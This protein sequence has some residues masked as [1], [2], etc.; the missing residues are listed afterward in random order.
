MRVSIVLANL[1]LATSALAAASPK[2][3]ARADYGDCRDTADSCPGGSCVIGDSSNPNSGYICSFPAATSSADS[4]SSSS[5][6]SSDSSSGSSGSYGDCRDTADSCPGGSCVAGDSSNPNSGYIC[7]FSSAAQTSAAASAAAAT[8]AKATTS[9]AAAGTAPTTIKAASTAASTT[10]RAASTT[11]L[12]ANSSTSASSSGSI[13]S[14]NANSGA[15]LTST[16]SYA[17]VAGSAYALL[18]LAVSL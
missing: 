7:S 12:A 15:G 16:V 3:I 1:A 8:S 10:S 18:S 14:G 9:A 4:A 2:L 5:S 17:V 6:S 11:A 13:P